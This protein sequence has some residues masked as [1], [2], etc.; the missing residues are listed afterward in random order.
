MTQQ[1][2]PEPWL[3]GDEDDPSSISSSSGRPV[4]ETL[5][6]VQRWTP[7]K[8][9]ED[10]ANARR[11]VAC[12][13][14]CKGIPTET[15]EANGHIKDWEGQAPPAIVEQMAAAL[16]QARH[17]WVSDEPEQVAAFNTVVAALDAYRTKKGG[18]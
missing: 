1:H 6:A 3:I 15:L 18:E 17:A 9:E 8:Q 10:Y 14:A 11:I 7:E 16:E 4:A 2:T 12:V 13:N 5:V